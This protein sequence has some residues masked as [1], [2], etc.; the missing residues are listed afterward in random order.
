MGFTLLDKW[1]GI[2]GLTII[3]TAMGEKHDKLLGMVRQ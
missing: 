3:D 2:L 1:R